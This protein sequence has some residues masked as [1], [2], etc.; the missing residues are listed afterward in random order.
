MECTAIALSW[1]LYLL[2][3]HQEE[4][5]QLRGELG[6]AP[7]DLAAVRRLPR[8]GRVVEET[9]RLYPPAWLL[10]RQSTRPVELG[11]HAFPEGSIL[12]VA[13]W[14]TH[15]DPRL[16]S[17]P[18]RFDPDR[19]AGPGAAAPPFAYLPFGGGARTCV[20]RPLALFLVRGILA[21]LLQRYRFELAGNR[22]VVPDPR[23][24]LRPRGG[25]PVVLRPV[26]AP[27][28]LPVTPWDR[29]G[30]R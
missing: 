19:F 25:L 21:M 10:A 6:D 13:P 17:E 8:L 29:A 14:V 9:L 15:R 1:A 22:R 26:S 24:T 5:R 23:L 18:E 3:R 27:P 11:G 2:A 7:P 12:F 20:G 16:W 4:E 28:G 30:R